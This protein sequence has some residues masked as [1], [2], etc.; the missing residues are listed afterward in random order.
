MSYEAGVVWLPKFVTGE[1]MF[2]T[3]PFKERKVGSN[4]FPLHYDLPLTKFTER[5]KPWLYDFLLQ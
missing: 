3:V 1:E 5:E 2:K 4:M